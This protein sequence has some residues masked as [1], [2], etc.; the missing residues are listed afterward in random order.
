MINELEIHN[1]KS[2]KDLTLPCKRF[3]LF[4][5]EPNTGKS[6]I[7]EALGL[8]SFIG[9][10]QYEPD[11]RLGG[12][13]RH[14]RTSNLFFDEEVGDPIKVQLDDLLVT[15]GY[16][17]GQYVGGIAFR[18]GSTLHPNV[19]LISG[20]DITI[21]RVEPISY[22]PRNE[23]LPD[24]IRFYRLPST[25]LHRRSTKNFLVPPSGVN[26]P[27]LLLQNR[28]LRNLVN[29]PLMASGLRLGL[30]PQENRIEVIK[31]ADDVIISYPYSLA[32]ETLQRITFYTAAIET[33]ENAVIVLEEPEAHS[34][35]G[36][37]KILA[38]Q[39]AMDENNNQYFIVTH[40]PYFLMPLLSKAPKD[41]IAINIVYSEDYQ[42][43]VRP[44]A[45]EELPELFE[46]NIF[47]N[48]KRYLEE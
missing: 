21:G 11:A 6:N 23:M 43:K 45:S 18:Q 13:V 39:I 37:T 8:V 10:R 19:T 15:F 14:E 2:I 12:F 36:E 32:S 4:I 20:D 42:T 44:L 33:N 29:S 26:L 3:N 47:A 9:V 48:L 35:P 38:E 27:S 24:R 28:E 7:L 34:F 22:N 41:D 31:Q 46:I 17:Q 16:Q 25:E 30:R 1:F 40:N 5:G